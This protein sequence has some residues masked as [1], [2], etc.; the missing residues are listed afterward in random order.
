M[1][2]SFAQ[3]CWDGFFNEP[4]NLSQVGQKVAWVCELVL[5]VGHNGVG[6]VCGVICM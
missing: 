2:R 6:W 4:V 1:R 3:N 5:Q